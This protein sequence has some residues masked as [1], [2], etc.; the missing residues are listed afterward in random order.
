MQV[1]G[2]PLAEVVG[3]DALWICGKDGSLQQQVLQTLFGLLKPHGIDLV[4]DTQVS[5]CSPH[6][7]ASICLSGLR[8]CLCPKA[9]QIAVAAQTWSETQENEFTFA[10]CAL[11]TQGYDSLKN[12]YWFLDPPSPLSGRGLVGAAVV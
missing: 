9:M 3:S 1:Q 11:Y 7:S 6:N 2:K 5:T 10:T 8:A 12:S 4:N